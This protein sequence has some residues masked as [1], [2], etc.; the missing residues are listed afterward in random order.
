MAKR[1]STQWD[2]LGNLLGA[3]ELYDA[4]GDVEESK[5]TIERLEVHLGRPSGV[6]LTL[7]RVHALSTVRRR[8]P[9][10]LSPP[11]PATL[12]N[13]SAELET[14]RKTVSDLKVADLNGPDGAGKS[15][16]AAALAHDLDPDLFPDG[17]VFVVGQIRHQDLL[18]ALFESFYESSAPVKITSQQ[19]HTYLYNLKA[20][21]ILDDV[22]LGPKQIDPILDALGNAAVLIASPERT[23]PGRGNAISLRGLPRPEAAALFEKVLG[24]RPTPDDHPII[25]QICTL[26][27][28]MPL[29]ISCVAAQ[30][31]QSQDSL[32]KLLTELRERKLWAGPGGDPSIG[33]SLEQIVLGMDGFERQILTLIATFAGSSVSQDALRTLTQLSGA[34]FQKRAERLQQ[35]GV[36]RILRSGSRQKSYPRLALVP[37]YRQ[38][39]RTWLVDDKARLEIVN[40][41][42]TRLNRGDRLPGDELPGLLGAI[43]DCAHNGWLTPLRSLVQATDRGLAWLGWWAEWQHVLD[44]TRRVAQAGGD[45]A[46]EAWAMHQLGSL[47]GALGSFER[48][49]HLLRTALNIRQVLGDEAGAALSA[50]NLQILEHLL[51][52]PVEEQPPERPAPAPDATLQEQALAVTQ[53]EIAALPSPTGIGWAARL[54]RIGLVTLTALVV[55]AIGAFALWFVLGGGKSEGPELTAS[56]EFGDAWNALDNESWTQQIVI[57]AQGG[58]GN[59][60]YFVN[61]EPVQEVFA[62]VLPLCDGARGTIQVQSGDGQTAQVEY[63]FDSPFCR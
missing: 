54:K 29:P 61:G 24:K 7:G 57:I 51:P 56:W 45:R 52:E 21:V 40:Y 60:D 55:L 17:V 33:P 41:Y 62:V 4:T 53:E 26:L 12:V 20:L 42:T 46:L 49:L 16:L 48:A 36:L 34:D 43:E 23:A 58:D 22:G 19:A 63:E 35:L 9:L 44:L 39:V 27:N 28:D 6:S 10:Y 1:F 37:A 30:A 59:Y 13:R 11:H 32:T 18:Q 8:R 25:E 50:H 15:T 47:L 38:A 31:A 14:L 2:V 3:C 5:I